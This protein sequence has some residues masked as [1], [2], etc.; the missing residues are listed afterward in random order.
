MSE[1]ARMGHWALLCYSILLPTL[2]IALC[3]TKKHGWAYLK[4]IIKQYL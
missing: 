3:P 2:S 4:I 1:K